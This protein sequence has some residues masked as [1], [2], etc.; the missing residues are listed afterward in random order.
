MDPEQD[1]QTGMILPLYLCGRRPF[2]TGPAGHPEAPGPLRCHRL[3]A[4]R[5]VAQSPASSL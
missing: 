4:A 2:V 5:D 1:G 3:P